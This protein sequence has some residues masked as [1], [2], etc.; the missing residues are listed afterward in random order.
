MKASKK[1]PAKKKT[2]VKT[3]S[4]KKISTKGS[5]RKI[6]KKPGFSQ[7]IHKTYEDYFEPLLNP[8][9]V[10][11]LCSLPA[12]NS[13]QNK[14]VEEGIKSVCN[15]MNISLAR[16]DAL[17]YNSSTVENVVFHSVIMKNSILHEMSFTEIDMRN[18]L[19][20]QSFVLCSVVKVN[21]KRA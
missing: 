18:L 4:I 9:C 13:T 2:A 10:I 8:P 15:V 6:S 17:V 1:T 14:A 5:T 3:K 19:L 16:Q 20:T 21:K 7:N 12:M 11:E